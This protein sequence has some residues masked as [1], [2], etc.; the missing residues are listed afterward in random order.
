MPNGM[1]NIFLGSWI[2][3]LTVYVTFFFY[4]CVYIHKLSYIKRKAV[5]EF[6]LGMPTNKIQTK[7][8]KPFHYLIR[9][10][11]C[12]VIDSPVLLQLNILRVVT[13]LK[14]ISRGES[15]ST[16]KKQDLRVL[17]SVDPVSNSWISSSIGSPS[18]RE[19][20]FNR[21]KA[22]NYPC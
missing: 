21:L 17:S 1:V 20:F 19:I 16:Q 9:S 11:K 6:T 10:C 18:D 22:L 14:S 2:H 7:T 15:H 8:W 5:L 12:S 4:I 13:A 3:H